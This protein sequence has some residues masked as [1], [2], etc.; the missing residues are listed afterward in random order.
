MP[1]LETNGVQLYHEVHGHGPTLVFTPGASWDHQ[2]RLPQVEMFGNEFQVVV[3][4]VRGHG[5]PILP[6][7]PVNS[8]EIKRDLTAVSDPRALGALVGRHH[9]HGKRRR[10]GLDSLP[11]DPEPHTPLIRS[12]STS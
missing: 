8:E 12:P 4:D 1:F 7:G 11:N 5:R 2:Q 10:P 6:P 9:A 3:W